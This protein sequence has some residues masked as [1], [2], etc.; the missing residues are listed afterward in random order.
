MTTHLPAFAFKSAATAAEKFAA[1]GSGSVRCDGAARSDS[2][3]Q[4]GGKGGDLAG[5]ERQT[6]LGLEAGRGRRALN[7]VQ[8]V[9]VEAAV[10]PACAG[11]HSR[12]P[13]AEI[14]DG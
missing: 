8:P 10:Q 1:A 9:H 7:R 11:R 2:S 14:R 4:S 5:L 6:M 13:D 12:R 3:R